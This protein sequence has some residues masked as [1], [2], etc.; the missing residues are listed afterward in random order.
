MKPKA[1][2]LYLELVHTKID[3]KKKEITINVIP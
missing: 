3:L 2:Y 1:L